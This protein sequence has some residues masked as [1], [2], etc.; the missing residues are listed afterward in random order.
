MGEG[1][2]EREQVIL[3]YSK[4]WKSSELLGEKSHTKS[5][6]TAS[7]LQGGSITGLRHPRRKHR[8]FTAFS[9]EASPVYNII[10]EESIAGLRHYL[11]RKHRRFTTFSKEKH[12]RFTAFS[13][14]EA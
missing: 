13:N 5:R 10:L 8:R 14:E 12:D 7:V 9:K 2:R 4:I 1:E 11:R 3:F 6:F